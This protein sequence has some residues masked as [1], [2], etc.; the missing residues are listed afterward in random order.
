MLLVRLVQTNRFCLLTEPFCFQ[1]MSAVR[2]NQAV[3]I[4]F[5]GSF[6]R[7]YAPRWNAISTATAVHDA[8]RHRRRS[9]G[10][11]WNANLHVPCYLNRWSG[12]K[13]FLPSS[14]HKGDQK[15]QDKQRSLNMCH[16]LKHIL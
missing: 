2:P 6:D 7:S 3:W 13:P 5:Y 15:Q 12:T 4:G 11:C 10:L 8:E 16:L 9:H 14:E 1:A